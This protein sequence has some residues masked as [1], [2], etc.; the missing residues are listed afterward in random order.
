MDNKF[1]N[2][3]DRFGENLCDE[4]VCSDGKRPRGSSKRSES[5]SLTRF[6][7]LLRNTETAFSLTQIG[8]L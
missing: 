7:R 1:V 2:I 4:I 3:K 6:P 8:E 5:E